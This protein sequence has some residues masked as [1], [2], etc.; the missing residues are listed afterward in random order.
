M[1][2]PSI[3]TDHEMEI[4]N[5]VDLMRSFWQDLSERDVQTAQYRSLLVYLNWHVFDLEKRFSL[6]AR[7]TRMAISAITKAKS[8][9]RDDI[10]A[11]VASQFHGSLSDDVFSHS[12]EKILR[13]WTML[14]VKIHQPK[15]C[16]RDVLIWGQDQTLAT[17]VSHYFELKAQLQPARPSG[18]IDDSLTGAC[19]V[20]DHGIHIVWTSNIAEHLT[21]NGKILKVFEHKIWAWNHSNFPE[22]SAV[23]HEVLEE[24]M[25]TWHLLF[26]PYDPGTE[27]FL[28]KHDMIETFYGLGF[29]GGDRWLDWTKYKYWHGEIQQLSSLLSE[30]PQ[31]LRRLIQP[32]N[33]RDAV[34]IALF[35][36][37][38]VMVAIL[39]IASCAVL[40]KPANL[41][42]DVAHSVPG[43][44]AVIESQTPR[45]LPAAPPLTFIGPTSPRCNDH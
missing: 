10:L 20:V 43:R 28:K 13:I 42:Q 1:S 23:P 38:G 40:I 27:S 16:P 5:N 3:A 7:G 33:R 29:C 11:L 4:S 19:L 26:P 17:V 44:K 14:D 12:L 25:N 30:S 37:T 2:P 36:V 21:M 39:A 24:L 9:S 18:A 45:H 34:D 22:S 31:G 35:W 15:Y 6:E 32:D 41:D 8:S